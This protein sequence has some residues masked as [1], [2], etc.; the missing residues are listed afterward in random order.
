MMGFLN[1]YFLM[2]LLSRLNASPT[3]TRRI[4]EW[5]SDPSSYV[6]SS[7][8]DSISQ[9]WPNSSAHIG[10]FDEDEENYDE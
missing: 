9:N 1:A 7:T 8:Y 3:A 10:Y 5:W 4:D 2:R 6:S